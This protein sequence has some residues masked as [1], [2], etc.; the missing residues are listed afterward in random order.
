[1]K[2]NYNFP[3]KKHKIPEGFVENLQDFIKEILRNQP[4]D[5][6][7]FGYAYFD[8]KCSVLNLHY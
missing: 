5:I 3:L 4:S 1:M 2:P 7:E 8:A 6:V